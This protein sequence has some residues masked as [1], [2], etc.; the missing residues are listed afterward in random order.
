MKRDWDE[1]A[2]AN[3]KF[4]INT[5]G[6]DQSDEE[7]DETGRPEVVEKILGDPVLL[8]GRDPRRMRLLEIG[9]GI[10][11]MTRHL[12]PHFLE[13]HG[14]DVSGEMIRRARAR[15]ARFPNLFF[16]E[17]SGSDF[18]PLPADYFDLAFSFYVFQHV[19][20]REVI[21]DNLRDALRV[22]KPGGLFKFQAVGIDDIDYE[23]LPKDTWTGASFPEAEIR[24]A[25]ADFGAQLVRI[26]DAGRKYCVTTLRK[27]D[28]DLTLPSAPPGIE[29][30]GRA[31]DPSIRAIPTNGPYAYL[32]LVISGQRPEAADATRIEVEVNGRAV[33]PCYAGAL[34]PEYAA[35]LASRGLEPLTQINLPVTPMLG[36]GPATAR[37][38]FAGGA[39]SEAS[40]FELLAPKPVPPRIHFVSNAVDGGLDVHARGDKS[41][42]RVFV[43]DL[44]RD[45][46][47]VRL[48]LD[49]RALS[50]LALSYI[51]ENG[52]HMIIADL[53]SNTTPGDHTLEL[54]HRALAA[55]PYTLHVI[56][57]TRE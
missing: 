50:P 32:T 8:A 41:R 5:V 24:R 19:P 16:H 35:A 33:W 1:R 29:L 44:E 56:E 4:F 30:I 45:P 51:P 17:T 3:A 38:R 47:E 43:F 23:A 54:S 9:C 20:S 13:V 21:R 14:V 52:V 53:P 40:S 7:F 2:R 57:E 18:A 6:L 34:G 25:A 26:T 46:K 36:A 48:L 27:P 10:G 39:W 15:L 28:A 22:L 11:R 42:F 12:A 49:G 37:A 55:T 31:D